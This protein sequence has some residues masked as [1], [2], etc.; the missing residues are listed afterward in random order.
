[1]TDTIEKRET[2]RKL[3]YCSAVGHLWYYDDD[4][5]PLFYC[6]LGDATDAE[7]ESAEDKYCGCND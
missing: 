6:N 4:G 7:A 1:M 5:T 2:G 3:Y